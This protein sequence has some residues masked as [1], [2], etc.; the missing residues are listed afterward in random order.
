[1]VSIKFKMLSLLV[2]EKE[3]Y[4]LNEPTSNIDNNTEEKIVQLIKEREF[5]R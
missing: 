2:D 5:I 1:M 3:V 4:L